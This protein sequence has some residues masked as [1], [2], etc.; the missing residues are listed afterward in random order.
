MES[1]RR[2]GYKAKRL[3]AC[4]GPH[5]ETRRKSRPALSGLATTCN[6]RPPSAPGKCRIADPAFF[7]PHTSELPK[8]LGF[9]QHPATAAM[10]RKAD[11]GAA[12]P[13]KE[14][15]HARDRSPKRRRKS[16]AAAADHD[17]PSKPQPQSSAPK[18]IFN[19]EEKAFPRGGASV[20]TPLEHKQIQIKANQDVLFEQAGLKRSGDDGL[21]DQGS[22]LGEEEAPKASKKRKSKKTKTSHADEAK[23]PK[24]KADGLSSKV[25][26]RHV[27]K[28]ETNIHRN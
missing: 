23:E 13:K 22:E 5:H 1:R 28:N 25:R 2:G 19:D 9:T 16:D 14:K 18:S 12:P 8:I 21:S 7:L 24:I 26:E 27:S 17:R 11:Q 10:K 15:G 4:T 20:L 3:E 6:P